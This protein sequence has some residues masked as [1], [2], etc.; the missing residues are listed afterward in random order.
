MHK[1]SNVQF[2][3]GSDSLNKRLILL[4]SLHLDKMNFDN[5]LHDD[6]TDLRQKL[7][8]DGVMLSSSNAIERALNF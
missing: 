2:K 3:V 8:A 1:K 4:E 7:A 6:I 5:R